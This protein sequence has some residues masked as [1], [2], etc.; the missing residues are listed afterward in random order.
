MKTKKQSHLGSSGGS[1]VLSCNANEQLANSNRK[2]QENLTRM[3]TKVNKQKSK[4]VIYDQK[5]F[6][7][8]A[9]MVKSKETIGF[10]QAC[11]R[12][13]SSLRDDFSEIDST[14][15]QNQLDQEP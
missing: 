2:M 15:E 6:S 4:V 5:L 8:C 1:D 10:N 14:T 11:S 3:F 12:I 13:G 9:D 7:V